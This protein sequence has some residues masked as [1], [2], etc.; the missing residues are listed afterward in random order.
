MFPMYE[1]FIEWL[2]SKNKSLRF[3][4]KVSQ[5]GSQSLMLVTNTRSNDVD[6]F[7]VW[8]QPIHFYKKETNNDKH[9]FAPFEVSKKCDKELT[10]GCR[11]KETAR[12]CVD[13]GL[14]VK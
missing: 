14:I 9:A 13:A 3:Y 10:P 7:R 2:R 4:I 12:I 5:K 1:P 11:N 8:L 6:K